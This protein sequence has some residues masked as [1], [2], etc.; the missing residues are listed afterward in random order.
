[1]TGLV[2][3]AWFTRPWRL[4]VGWKLLDGVGDLL[5]AVAERSAGATDDILFTLLLAGSRLAVVIAGG[6]GVAYFLSIPTVDVLAGLGIGGLA[7]AFASWETLANVFGAGIL[8]TDRPFR[9][10]DWIRTGDIEGAVESVGVRS[11]QVC[12]AQDSVV[13]IPNGKLVDSTINNL[14]AR[15]FRLVKLQL[16]VTSGGTRERLERFVAA[17]RERIAGERTIVDVSGVSHQQGGTFVD[18]SAY[19]DGTTDAAESDVRNA[20]LL[21]LFQVARREG[22]SLGS[23]M[24]TSDT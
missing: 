1:M 20:L 14:G 2:V 7:L 16:P 18:I 23:G 13:F 5:G 21:D 15:R 3:P 6:L 10:R 22:L 17:V 12:T 19:I 8:V 11:T 4:L 24:V 9:R